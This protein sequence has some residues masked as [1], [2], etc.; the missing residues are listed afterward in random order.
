MNYDIFKCSGKTPKCKGCNCQALLWPKYLLSLGQKKTKWLGQKTEHLVSNKKE[1]V[2]LSWTSVLD[3]DY[4]RTL[5]NI[6]GLWPVLF[7]FIPKPEEAKIIIL[8]LVV[9]L[10]PNKGQVFKLEQEVYFFNSLSAVKATDL[11]QIKPFWKLK[12]HFWLE[13]GCLYSRL[14][15]WATRPAFVLRPKAEGCFAVSHHPLETILL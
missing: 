3:W 14:Q 12:E 5:L 15:H 7:D 11:L 9:Y 8:Y 4:L 1:V 2:I 10:V 13:V 6:P